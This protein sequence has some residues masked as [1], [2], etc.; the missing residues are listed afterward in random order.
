MIIIYMQFTN[1]IIKYFIQGLISDCFFVEDYA[2][3]I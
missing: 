2:A 1:H 3:P